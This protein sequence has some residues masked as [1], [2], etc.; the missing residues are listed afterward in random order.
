MV[1]KLEQMLTIIDVKEMPREVLAAFINGNFGFMWQ[2]DK[3]PN[4]LKSTFG[5]M[6]PLLG[7]TPKISDSGHDNWEQLVGMKVMA[8]VLLNIS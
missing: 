6:T 2:V 8:L 4:V 5:G 1:E 7:T 3:N